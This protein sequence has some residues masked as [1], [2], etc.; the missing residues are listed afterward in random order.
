ML[1]LSMCAV[2]RI[3]G[4]LLPTTTSILFRLLFSLL[5]YRKFRL[6]LKRFGHENDDGIEC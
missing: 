4:V 2:S 5:L 6:R 3:G 1:G